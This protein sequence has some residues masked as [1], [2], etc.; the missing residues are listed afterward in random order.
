MPQMPSDL[1]DAIQR[2][3]EQDWNEDSKV[4]VV[5]QQHRPELKTKPESDPP[6]KSV[7]VTVGGY[8]AKHVNQ[9]A[10][11]GLAALAILVGGF[12]WL[13]TH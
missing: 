8:G 2:L 10:F 6:S 13:A 1:D 5:V 9:W 7:S 3:A 4:T 11:F 12:V